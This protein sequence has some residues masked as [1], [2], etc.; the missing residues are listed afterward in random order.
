[1]KA[2]NYIAIA[3]ILKKA[4]EMIPDDKPHEFGRFTTL[5]IQ[6]SSY[7]KTTNPKFDEVR[8]FD[9]IYKH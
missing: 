9:L 5:T 8:F 4:F 3:G 2:K 7:L 6:L 1:M